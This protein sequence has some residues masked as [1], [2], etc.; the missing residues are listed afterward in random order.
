MKEF[1]FFGPG[2]HRLKHDWA[3]EPTCLQEKKKPPRDDKKKRALSCLALKKDK[4]RGS[5]ILFS[6]RELQ[7]WG[8]IREGR[9]LHFSLVE[10]ERIQS[11]IFYIEHSFLFLSI[12]I[13]VTDQLSALSLFFFYMEGF[14]PKAAASHKDPTHTTMS[15][16]ESAVD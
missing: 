13:F 9:G 12:N 16:F 3:L 7:D 14:P 1:T 15:P 6:S 10:A 2:E 5:S 4:G 11:P 8:S